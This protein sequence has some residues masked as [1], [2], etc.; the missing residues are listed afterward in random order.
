M[1]NRGNCPNRLNRISSSPCH[2]SFPSSNNSNNNKPRPIHKLLG[3]LVPLAHRNPQ[4]QA[5]PLYSERVVAQVSLGSR[6]PP[7]RRLRSTSPH[8]YSAAVGLLL[9]EHPN[10]HLVHPRLLQAK[11]HR[12]TNQS[13]RPVSM[14]YRKRRR[15][16]ARLLFLWSSL[17]ME[18]RLYRLTDCI[19]V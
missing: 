17:Y 3:L 19:I 15:S 7:H 12:Q 2:S 6:N 5:P 4:P 8:L 1:A 10:R 18:F 9:L 14:R 13:T 11:Y 16:F